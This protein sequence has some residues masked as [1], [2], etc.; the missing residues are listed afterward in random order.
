MRQGA[1]VTEVN[2]FGETP[3]HFAAKNNLNAEVTRMLVH[4]GAPVATADFK[5][6]TL[7]HRAAA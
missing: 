1:L 2:N 7:L 6:N 4:N 3:L 5:G